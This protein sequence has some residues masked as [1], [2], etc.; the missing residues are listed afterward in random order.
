MDIFSYVTLVGEIV[1]P[2]NGSL[3]ARTGIEGYIGDVLIIRGGYNTAGLDWQSGGGDDILAGV[4][5]GLGFR[6]HGYQLDYCFIPMVQ[7][8]VAHRLSLAFSL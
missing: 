7:L 1:K 4:T 8:G 5:T 6:W 2:I 3:Q